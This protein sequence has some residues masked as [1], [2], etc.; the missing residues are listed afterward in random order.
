MPN[1]NIGDKPIYLKTFTLRDV[2]D[3]VDIQKDIK[4]GM[5]LIIRITPL[6]QKDVD[7]LRNVVESLFKSATN[8]GGDVARL[9]EER[10]II[11]PPE[12]KIWHNEI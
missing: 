3:V 12:V 5:I 2:K 4:K 7:H 8:L 6:A 11:T 9:G 1:T 10:I